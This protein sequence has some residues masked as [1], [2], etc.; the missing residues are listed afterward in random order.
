M[1][2][3]DFG[4]TGNGA[5]ATGYEYTSSA[6]QGEAQ[7]RSMAATISGSTSKT[8]AFELNAVL[9]L[10]RNGT[11]YSYWIQNGLHLD[12]SSDLFNIGGAYVWNFSAPGATLGSGEV[13]GASGS[14]Y[15]GGDTYYYYPAC[16]APYAGQCTTLTLPAVLT[17]R[18]VSG[19]A[20]GL[21]YV[22]YEYNLGAGWVTYDNVSFLHMGGANVSGFLVDGFSPAPYS[23][24][25]YYD[26]EWV[27]V[28]AGGGS[29]AVDQASD[30]N[31][32]LE[33]WN[34]HNYQAIP[35]AWNF[36]SD[37]GETNS[38]VTDGL[39]TEGPEA[40]LTSGA[41][42]LG[43]LYGESTIGYAEIYIPTSQPA[44]IRVDGSPT[45][46][47]GGVA[48]L[49]LFPGL[50]S[51]TLENYSNASAT[52]SVAAG[53]TT[54]VL[55]SGAGRLLFEEKGLPAGTQWGVTVNGT[56]LRTGS[57]W[58]QFYLANGTYPVAYASVGGYTRNATSPSSV[59]LPGVSEVV[60]NF[61]VTTYRI[62]MT[63]SGL[64]PT[65]PWWVEVGSVFARSSS[66]SVTLDLPNG[67]TPFEAGAS[68]TFVATPS[69]GT[70]LVSAGTAS[71]PEIQF[72]YRPC[73][74][75]G[76]ITPTNATVL[77]NGTPQS[78][79]GGS[80]VDQVIPGSYVVVV[81]AAGFTSQMETIS[82]TPG[83][84][85]WANFTLAAN[86]TRGGT[87]PSTPSGGTGTSEL[88]AVE[89]IVG[90]AIGAGVL[91][92]IFA[93]RRRR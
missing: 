2:I 54:Q 41:G 24:G 50:H 16:S 34:G 85:T 3:A 77:V 26:A 8:M 80:Y 68:Y 18:I 93:L 92:S 84:T 4:V 71:P 42:T 7:I 14:T 86:Q 22:D 25:L 60:L 90:V 46:L 19:D 37:T 5:A 56:S 44:T 23:A 39:S 65:T 15:S 87:N 32:T 70:I 83:N 40:H 59:T 79:S 29:E 43:L 47:V 30:I 17:G 38:N 72:A 1:G 58:M 62:P 82:A 33:Y 36:G 88:V 10:K 73:Y 52:F 49:T 12:A 78:V 21:P 64:P 67:S 91:I 35:N 9:F 57:N 81:S 74:L 51:V 27:W 20:S 75:E 48:N 6:F 66:D 69:A 28:G 53:S 31:L 76:S 89:V 13:I 61:S 11:N 55:L 63:E 45:N